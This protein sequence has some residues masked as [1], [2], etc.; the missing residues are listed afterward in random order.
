M[1]LTASLSR[2]NEEEKV[3]PSFIGFKKASTKPP[4]LGFCDISLSIGE[5]GISFWI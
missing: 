3:I 1:D 5:T 2:P 4:M